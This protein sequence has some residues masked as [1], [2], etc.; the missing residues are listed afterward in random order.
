VTAWLNGIPAEQRRLARRLDALVVQAMPGAVQAIKYRKP[1]APLG[2]PFY[3]LPETG[4]IL[5][6]NE[7]KGRVRLTFLAGGKLKPMPPLGSGATRAI[8]IPNDADVDEKQITAWLRQAK[9]LPGWGQ[10]SG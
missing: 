2:V 4:W 6:V 8:D 1:S 3:G 9:K 5:H 10:V 7:L